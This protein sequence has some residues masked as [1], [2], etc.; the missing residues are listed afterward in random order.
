[1][2]KHIILGAMF[3]AI[4]AYPSGWR[5]PGAHHDPLGDPQIL[6]R[7][8][9]LAEAAKF[10]YFF[11][12]DWLATGFDL[13]YRDPYLLARIDPLSAIGFLSGVTSRIGLIAT[14]NS[15]YSDPYTLA[16]Q[17]AAID[18]LSGGR[19]GINLVTG[20]EPRAA[21]NHGR[22]AHDD[23][24]H[25]YDRASE[26][27]TVL[28]KLWDS[29]D[30]DAFVADQASGIFVDRGGLHEPEFA[31]EQLSVSGA[32]NVARPVQGHLPIVHA[33]TSPRSREL[34]IQLADLALV[35]AP[36]LEAARAL[37][38]GFREGAT[39]VGRNPDS[40]R[41][42]APVLPV[43]AETD[44][45]A[46][47]I[48][49]RLLL[50]VPL[51]DGSGPS[52]YA[53]FPVNRSIAALSTLVGVDLGDTPLDAEIPR[54]TVAQFSEAGA[55][56]VDSVASRTGRTIGGEHAITYRH[57]LALHAAPASPVV[58]SASF[59]ADHLDSWFSAGAVD[60][61]NVLTPFHAA[62]G[63]P[64]DQFEAFT[65]LV[66]PELRRRGLFRT[67]Y[68]GSTLRDHLGLDRPHSVYRSPTH[69]PESV[70]QNSH[71]ER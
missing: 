26:F 65:A 68:D 12:G 32:L 14:A 29:W 16:R 28:R 6:K 22:A 9:R 52:V 50:L 55:N 47:D 57:I 38:T 51:A 71:Q 40:L 37:R 24:A 53:D 58:G 46:F 11:V 66:V 25:R 3:R 42:I 43:V 54:R 13:E 10:D 20:A 17:A 34:V 18:R 64:G 49:D 33:G 2:S 4:G 19:A 60:G 31:G 27:V 23:N 15:T 30:D 1:M 35:G 61:F 5:F 48:F 41:T 70:L 39:A 62:I 44:A 7:T 21:G 69:S 56:L 67:E 63:Q 8:A 59:V 45:A 36:T